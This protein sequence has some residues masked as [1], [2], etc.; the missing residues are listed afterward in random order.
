MRRKAKVAL[1]VP[2]TYKKENIPAIIKYC[3]I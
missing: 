3:L 1:N 2:S